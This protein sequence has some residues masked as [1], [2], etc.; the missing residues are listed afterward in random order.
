MA[1]SW[2]DYVDTD[3]SGKGMEQLNREE[4]VC[5]ACLSDSIVDE[6][7]VLF[8]CSTY[9]QICAECNNLFQHPSLTVAPFLATEQ[10]NVLG[11]YFKTRFG[12]RQFVLTTPQLA[13]LL[14]L[15]DLDQSVASQTFQYII[16]RAISK[17]LY[18]QTR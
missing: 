1:L 11:S 18:C 5:H 8:D 6:H 3:R 2:H 15:I 12:H 10:P 17:G 14:A 7:H 16:T 9:S 4:R 13:W